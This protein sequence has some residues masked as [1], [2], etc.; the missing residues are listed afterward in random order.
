MDVLAQVFPGIATLFVE[1][2]ILG[3]VRV[4]LTILG[5]VL[6]YFGFKGKLEPLIM[7]PMGLGMIAVNCGRA[8]PRRRYHRYL[9]HRPA[10][11]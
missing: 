5:F 11:Q 7:V 8:V 1:D 3:V 10:R 4:G 9:D 6:A 2:P